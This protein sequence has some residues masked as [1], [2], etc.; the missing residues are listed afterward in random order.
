MPKTMPR[1]RKRKDRNRWTQLDSRVVFFACDAFIKGQ[2]APWIATAIRKRFQEPLYRTQVY[3]L[4]GEGLR[5]GFFHLTPPYEFQLAERMMERF[6]RSRSP[7]ITT[8]PPSGGNSNPAD[9]TDARS[10]T[11]PKEIRVVS[12]GLEPS[13]DLV[14]VATAK[15]ALEIITRLYAKLCAAVGKD[16]PTLLQVSRGGDGPAVHVGFGAGATTQRV[17]RYLA[18]RLRGLEN[19][20]L[21]VL[22]ALSS[23]F[24][25]TQPATAP[26]AFF[27]YFDGMPNVEFRGLFAPA[28]ARSEEWD[29]MR[30]LV[31]VRESFAE[32][33]ALQVI[34][35][36]LATV[37]DPHGELNR[38]MDL[39]AGVGAEEKRILDQTERREGDVMYRPFS[40]IG[41]ITRTMAVRPVTLFELEELREF[42]Q[43]EDHAVVLVAG[44]CADCKKSRTRALLP[45]L[46]EPALSVWTHLVTDDITALECLDGVPARTS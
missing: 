45:L 33:H 23:G 28:Y 4:L 12:H 40:G 13:L 16:P 20:P 22:H 9:S 8:P 5:R 30:Q 25:V 14:A 44:P 32:K 46:R 3:A 17:A 7:Q 26:V 24:N 29:S 37:D 10:L 1:K 39:N 43:Q 19:P 27:S 11:D 41:P 35:T 2:K 21:I 42:V 34:I 15:T 6:V 38:F 31:G 18:E 36:S